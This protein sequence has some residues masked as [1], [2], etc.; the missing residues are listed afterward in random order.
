MIK[1]VFIRSS[2]LLANLVRRIS[3]RKN[4][5]LNEVP[6]HVFILT[7]ASK[8]S[9]S[10]YLIE[11][12]VPKVHKK[13]V[14]SSYKDKTEIASFDLTSIIDETTSKDF[15]EKA[16]GSPYHFSACI[17]K[18]WSI[19][20]NKLNQIFHIPFHLGLQTNDTGEYMC[21]EL[22]Q[23]CLEAS[24]SSINIHNLLTISEND[25]SCPTSPNDLM[26]ALRELKNETN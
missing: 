20:I 22:V 9:D 4:Q 19:W 10:I 16:I 11:A 12:V 18:W 15:L 5:K 1:I 21:S 24:A 2:G 17:A 23:K 6:A 13:T 25:F 14:F 26:L 7:D 3:C 8:H